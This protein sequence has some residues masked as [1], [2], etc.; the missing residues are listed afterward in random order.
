MRNGSEEAIILTID[1]SAKG[2]EGNIARAFGRKYAEAWEELE[3]Q[4]EYPISLGAAKIYEIE[5]ELE[6]NN[7]Y[8]FIA[9]TLHHVE[10]LDKFQ[11]LRILGSAMRSVLSLASVKRISSISSAVLIGGWRLEIE[12]A[13]NEMI[14][15]YR[16]ARGA[17]S[18]TP[19]L[20][21]YILG[22]TVFQRIG[23]YIEQSYPDSIRTRSGYRL[24]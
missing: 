17:F 16:V 21:V 9:S 3:C 10:V 23:K 12:D 14:K 22:A 8:C 5:S 11:K 13:L 20:R 7:K 19:L 18:Y 6:C 15:T 4:I 2:L 24:E 1:G